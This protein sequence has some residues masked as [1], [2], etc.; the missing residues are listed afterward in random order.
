LTT[1]SFQTTHIE[2]TGLATGTVFRKSQ[3]VYGVVDADGQTFECDL[4]NTLR[5]ALVYPISA[6][7]KHPAT[8]PDGCSRC[9]SKGAR[10]GVRDVKGIEVVDPVAVGDRVLFSRRE[11]GIGL[12][13]EVLPRRTRLVRR[14]SGTKVLEQVLV[15]NV[16]QVVPVL[17][18][19]EP[20]PSWELLDRYLAAAEEEELP[21]CIVITKTDLVSEEEHREEAEVYSC[22]GYDLVFTSAASG[23]GIDALRAALKNKVSIFCGKS[24]VGKTTLLNVLQ[25]E[26]GQR[27]A[28]V[29][30]G[31][32]A[33]GKGRHTTTQVEMFALDGGGAVVDSPGMREF[34]LW[35]RSTDRERLEHE[36][37]DLVL[38]FRDLRP[39][40]GQCRF[41]LDCSHTHEPGC[42]VKQ[43][44]ESGNVSRRRYLSYLKIAGR[45][46]L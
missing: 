21:S 43:A 28:G 39:Y 8:D 35:D 7:C 2:T 10:R 37:L 1:E 25:P 29:S 3:G 13:D 45:E 46:P 41:G 20:E 5:K 40:A 4:P 26:L 22:L 14:A 36:D 24:G 16:D 19:K 12:I 38:L 33:A 32:P 23:E 11:D 17:A 27:V 42:T 44:V 30:K 9:R 6:G 34:G 18:A 31:G 15:A